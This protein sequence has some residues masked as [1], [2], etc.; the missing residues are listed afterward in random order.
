VS[1]ARDCSTCRFRTQSPSRK[2][3]E[4]DN[5]GSHYFLARHWAQ[6]L[7]SQDEDPELAS[8]F[9]RVAE[10]LATR[11]AEILAELDAAQGSPVDI[12]GYFL[13]DDAKADAAMRPS[14]TL[15]G[16]LAEV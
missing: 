15:N 16:I 14:A 4:F 9:A 12:G 1:P 3:G 13:P 10:E 5:C 7:A 6:A 8:R 2:V 11:E